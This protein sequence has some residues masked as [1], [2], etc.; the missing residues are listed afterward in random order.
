[1]HV[2][3]K[4]IVKS[5]ATIDNVEFEANIKSEFRSQSSK[6]QYLTAAVFQNSTALTIY[7]QVFGQLL[8]YPKLSLLC[9]RTQRCQFVSTKLRDMTRTRLLCRVLCWWTHLFVPQLNEKA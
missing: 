9:Q 7:L 5:S 2:M 4:E 8:V 3:E 6:C 1:M